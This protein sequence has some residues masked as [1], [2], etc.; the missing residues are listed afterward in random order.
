MVTAVQRRFVRLVAAWSLAVVAV[1]AA[2]DA[3]RPA[4]WFAGTL[5]GFL[6]LVQ[7]TASR[8]AVAPW[9]R[10]L[11]FPLVVGIALFGL[12]AGYAL[13]GRFGLV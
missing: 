4:H 1:L 13:L 12:A 10:R 2:I 3:L 8:V 11:R 9:R 5:L 7:F 6:L